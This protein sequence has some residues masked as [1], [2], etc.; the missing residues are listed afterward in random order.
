MKGEEE[1]LPHT[2][3]EQLVAMA[4]WPGEQVVVEISKGI[5]RND[6]WQQHG[7]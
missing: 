4:R 7:A 5:K 3:S 6:N 1:V 2:Q